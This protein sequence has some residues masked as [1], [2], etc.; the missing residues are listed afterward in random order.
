M[1]TDHLWF[2]DMGAVRANF[3]VSKAMLNIQSNTISTLGNAAQIIGAGNSIA[4]FMNS[5]SWAEKLAET[6][7]FKVQS[8]LANSFS[9]LT[10]GHHIQA[11]NEMNAWRAE[12]MK[13]FEQT[14]YRVPSHQPQ[15]FLSPQ[16]ENT[17]HIHIH[18]HIDPS[19]LD[20]EDEE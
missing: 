7:L 19:L 2:P 20:E 11:F 15:V 9:Q 3:G 16:S 6:S 13:M 1:N 8:Q 14:A 10:A 12:A 17:T 18:L 5:F 4:Q